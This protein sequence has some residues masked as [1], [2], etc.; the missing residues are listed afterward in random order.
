VGYAGG[1]T[2]N[3]TYRNIGDHTET[4]EID[5]DPTVISYENLLDVFWKNHD[6][7]G[8]PGR[9][10]YMS[11]VFYHDDEQK[12]A[13]IRTRDRESSRR[14]ARMGTEIL[15]ASRFTLAEGYHQKY[16]L[17]NRPELMREYE[18]IYPSYPDFLAS[19]AVARVNGYAAGYG[20]CEMLREE[21]DGLGLS[22][23][24]RK[25]LADIVG[26]HERN[27]GRGT[28]TACPLD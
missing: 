9:R 20:T 12:D 16:S 7:V 23:A 15:P 8:R 22:P 28:G 10:Q 6:P 4:V 17:R 18:G 27:A 11:I 25:R 24:G 19:T 5:F 13:A 21:I 2:E 14:N 26:A 1:S 3:P